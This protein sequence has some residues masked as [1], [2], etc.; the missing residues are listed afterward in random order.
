MPR[1]CSTRKCEPDDPVAEQANLHV[2][3]EPVLTPHDLTGFLSLLCQEPIPA[4][5]YRYILLLGELDQR[6]GRHFHLAIYS[7]P[8]IL[9]YLDIFPV[10]CSGTRSACSGRVDRFKVTATLCA[11][12]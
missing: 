3:A 6:L 12:L 2:A 5:R 4:G 11:R 1:P 9:F 7:L 10:S 8:W